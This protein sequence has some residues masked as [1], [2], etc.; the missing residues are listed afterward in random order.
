MQK[1]ADGNASIQP[2]DQDGS[3]DAV[4][5]NLVALVG[6]IQTSAKLV[7]LAI[8]SE[9]PFFDH[10][11]TSNIVVLDDVTPRYARASAVLKNCRAELGAALH[12]LMDTRTS[13]REAGSPVERDYRAARLAG[14][15]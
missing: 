4:I 13:A 8:A 12:S 9:T 14:R 11:T 6:H 15:S 2:H 3:H 7:E 10:D 5:A 1:A